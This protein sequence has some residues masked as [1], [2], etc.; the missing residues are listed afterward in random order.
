MQIFLSLISL[1]EN[2]ALDER[3]RV[4]E[5]IMKFLI[6]LSFIFN[7]RAFSLENDEILYLLKDF[8]ANYSYE[9]GEGFHQ[10]LFFL[11]QNEE[12]K[13]SSGKVKFFKEADQVR[14]IIS[15]DEFYFEKPII[16][17]ENFETF[18]IES[19]HQKRTENSF[20][21]QLNKFQGKNAEDQTLVENIVLQCKKDKQKE[22][23]YEI[24]DLCTTDSIITFDN[25][26]TQSQN[27]DSFFNFI[28]LF[29]YENFK[30]QKSSLKIKD[31]EFLSKNHNFILK[32]EIQ[33]EMNLKLKIKGESYYIS[34]ENHLKIKINQAFAGPFPIKKQLF[35]F[36]EKQG[37]Q[38]I[39]IDPPYIYITK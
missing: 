14:A 22:I 25:W 20:F 15:G 18:K 34:D 23:F 12:I 9:E 38:N 24:V 26:T 8:S 36:L 33:S 5:F 10:S 4:L 27:K 13:K 19:L 21:F 39:I 7:F 29:L 32:M 17:T 3:I 11:H 37:H 1:K 31:L 30:T 2:N 6:F 35:D 28:S 16:F